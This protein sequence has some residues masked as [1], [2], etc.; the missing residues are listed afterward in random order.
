MMSI[1]MGVCC[2]IYGLMIR[3][4]AVIIF[5]IYMIVDELVGDDFVI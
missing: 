5:G 4:F 3:D 2:I 1:I